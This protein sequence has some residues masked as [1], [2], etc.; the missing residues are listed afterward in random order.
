[1]LSAPSTPTAS[2][3]VSPGKPHPGPMRTVGFVVPA[4]APSTGNQWARMTV[5]SNDAMSRSLGA[6]AT[7]TASTG[8]PVG[9]S[10]T[11][12]AGASVAV[13]PGAAAVP[14]LAVDPVEPDEPAVLDGLVTG[15]A[16]EHADTARSVPTSAPPSRAR[17]FR[18]GA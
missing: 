7:G 15:S 12:A 9:A 5:P 16:D 3:L 18:R 13:P 14:G 11:A 6:S 2:T 4:P 1:M 17:R 8:G 10:Q